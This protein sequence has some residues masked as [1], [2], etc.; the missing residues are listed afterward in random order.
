LT[1]I[2][3]AFLAGLLPIHVLSHLVSIGTLL[4]F[5]IVC[6]AVMILRKT[7]PDAHRAFKT[8]FFPYVPIAGMLI[9][10]AQMFALPWDTW[11][12]FVLWLIIGFAIYFFYSFR[13]SALAQSNK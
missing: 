3:A 1:G 8:P 13:R 6:A 7:Q 4:A 10:M 9:C 11:M 12:R 5:T 2:I